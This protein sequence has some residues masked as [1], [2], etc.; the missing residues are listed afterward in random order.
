M[1]SN[2]G[3]KDL[4][5]AGVHFGHQTRKWNPKMKDHIFIARGGIHIID[6]QKTLAHVERAHAFLT[7]VA[8]TGKPILFVATKKQARQPVV[9]AA[10]SCSMPHVTERWL[11]GMLTN[12]Q[13]ISKSITKLDEI[14]VKL[15]ETES[16]LSK[17]E[18]LLMTRLGDKLRRNLGGIRE[19]NRLPGALF[20]IDT[21]EESIAIK[22]AN[23]LGIPVV[24]VVDSNADP[25]VIQFPIP[26]ND[27][28]IRAIQL[29]VDMALDA[30]AQGKA[31]GSEGKNVGAAKSD[32]AAAGETS[33]PAA[34]AKPATSDAS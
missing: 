25:D 18:T 32:S 20:V 34:E 14:D 15:A 5:E 9:K 21:V 8:A 27:D 23:K 26:G 24:G 2:I 3:L 12:F 6:L 4:L 17:K 19:M 16:N 10:E 22:E 11:G 29:F 33:E 13:T 28:A 1:S 30:I 7:G 31:Q